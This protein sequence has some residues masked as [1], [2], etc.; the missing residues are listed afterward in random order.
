MEKEFSYFFDWQ[1]FKAS[2]NLMER[3][4]AEFA[5]NDAKYI[6]LT[7]NLLEYCI[8]E[9][10]FFILFV[11]L[12]EKYGLKFS[13]CHGLWSGVKDLNCDDRQYRDI[14]IANHKRAMG[15]AADAGCKEYV[16]HIGALCCYYPPYDEQLMRDYACA[17]LDQLVPEA[18]KLG[19]II[20]VE[21]SFEPT[22]TADEVLYYIN[23][24]PSPAVGVCYDAGHANIMTSVGKDKS[25][26]GEAMQLPWSNKIEF[27]DHALEKLAPH[28]VTCHLHDNDGYSD[29]HALPG[30]G[31][32]NWEKL[33]KDLSACPRI[34][35]MQAEIGIK[36]DLSIRKLCQTFDAMKQY[37][38]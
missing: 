10:N 18:E 37:I 36:P 7:N 21:N 28:I 16:V 14:S 17:T 12:L 2:N 30:N 25:R 13:G 3:A 19:I 15:Y 26:Y 23:K 32:I 1:N 33:I 31:I 35:S 9:P 8:S 24:F 27:E 22:N 20:A 6:V 29:Q 4:V 11:K 38:R 5:A 34:L